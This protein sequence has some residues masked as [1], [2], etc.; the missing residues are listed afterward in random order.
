MRKILS[1]L[2]DPNCKVNDDTKISS[3]EPNLT[4]KLTLT[5]KLIAHLRTWYKDAILI[6][7]KLLENNRNID[8][9]NLIKKYK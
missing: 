6:G 4:V 8:I 5:T 1:I 9:V 7:F 2:T 3:Y